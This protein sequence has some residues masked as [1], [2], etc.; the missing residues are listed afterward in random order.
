DGSVPQHRPHHP[1]QIVGTAVG[2]GAASTRNR[3]TGNRRIPGGLSRALSRAL[4]GG[5]AGGDP[6]PKLPR[7]EPASAEK[8]ETEG[9]REEEAAVVF[10]PLERGKGPRPPPPP[11]PPTVFSSRRKP[12]SALARAGGDPGWRLFRGGSPP[13]LAWS[14]WRGGGLQPLLDLAEVV[15]PVRA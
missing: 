3:S 11:P 12:L 7:D 5:V 9:K 1:H 14:G 2:Q 4:G 8:Q 10:S 6:P 15:L 13:A